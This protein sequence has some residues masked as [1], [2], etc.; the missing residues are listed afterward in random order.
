MPGPAT[1]LTLRA[2]D[3]LE[4]ERWLASSSLRTRLVQRA[5]IVLLAADGVSTQV[6]ADRVG[7]SRP[8]VNLWRS[9]YA[10][11]G[12]SGLA[13][14]DRSGR[15][16][17]AN[18]TTIVSGVADIA[19][20]P[21]LA[22]KLS[23]PR[24]RRA[25]V[26][27]QSLYARLDDGVSR[28]V[29]II[30]APAGFG[31]S[32]LLASWLAGGTTKGRSVAWLSLST[33]DNDPSLFWRY[34]I[35]A[36]SRLH[37]GVGATASALMGSPQPPRMATIL[38]TM[39]NDLHSVTGDV[40]IVLDDYQLIDSADIHQAMTFLIENR[41]PRLHLIILTRA[42]PPL[43]LSR[44]RASG[45]LLELRAADL[46]FGPDE[47]GTYLN[48]VMGL[49]LTATNISEL[50]RRTE[51]WVAGLQMAALA[52]RDQAEVPAFIAGFT[53]S[54]RYVIDYLAEEVLGRQPPAVRAFLLDTSVLD[55]MCASLCEEITSRHDSQDI[56]E[57]L[58]HAN[59][60]VDPL[61]EVRGW[62]RYHQLFADVLNQRLRHEQHGRVSELHR[63]ASAWYERHGLFTDAVQHAI[64]GNDVDRAIRLIE[65]GG[66]SLVLD[67]QVQT[68]LSWLD[69]L[70]AERVREHPALSTIRALGYVF[71]NRP[72]EAE[73]SLRDAERC[74]PGQPTTDGTRAVLG[75][76]AVIR[77]AICRF[78]GDI[79]RSVSLGQRA[80]QL[81]PET[82][83]TSRE[84]ASAR[85]HVALTYQVNGD[86]RPANERPLEEAVAAFSAAHALV[87]L[88]NSINRLGKF[89]TMQGRLRAAHATYERAAAAVSNR[90]GQ[91]AA[92]NSAAYYAGMGEIC[93]QWNDLDSAEKYL[94]QAVDLVAGDLTVD[95][96]AVTESHLSLARLHEARGRSVEAYA[97]L[98]QFLSLA[99]QR[100]FFH[101]LIQR[102]EAA[103]ARLALLQ[104]D[105][106]A[107]TGWADGYGDVPDTTYTREEQHLTLTRILIARA[108]N[109]SADYLNEALALLQRMFAA[110]TGTGRTNSV[111]EILVLQA[112]ALHARHEGS[113]AIQAVERALAL[114][115]SERYV[116]V[117]VDEGAPMA[118]LLKDLIQARRNTLH[119]QQLGG[120]LRYARRLLTEF[121]PRDPSG[122]PSS[123]PTPHSRERPVD[124]SLSGR[125]REVLGLIA[126][127]LSN[128]EIAA[129]MYVATSTVKSYTNSIFRRLGVSSRTQAVA[130][131]RSLGLLSD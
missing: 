118:A 35:A 70:P 57:G 12:L 69:E 94:R 27:R 113:A 60:F 23:V 17:R 126:A 53:G 98:D 81:L 82:D 95:A 36:I 80:L 64:R 63:R 85:T 93:L 129:R 28:A 38:T 103:L 33:A 20:D 124:D 43:P 92:V 9:R 75:R 37:P 26:P 47:S 62:Y 110:A 84:R 99:R 58:E 106:A 32:T 10:H 91:P 4:L 97:V 123:T 87:P 116:R 112:L 88:L 49:Q 6:I 34:F 56:L 39:I 104:H 119:D 55:R 96:D 5:Q 52:I 51:G 128:R 74:L 107:A 29:V 115:E 59:L 102:G 105:L 122:T 15:P 111:I 42:D 108:E 78:S 71:S 121:H 14:Q 19:S 48:Q 101:L 125:E 117:F 3:R 61:D 8:T 66:M 21:L 68:V 2:D 67:Q 25:V 22:T 114:A 65:S 76:V 30:S 86:V 18:E 100:A 7:V 79:E 45:E 50:V 1:A 41:P 16:S 130:E 31:K 89:R 54:N 11:S 127:G 46:R 77:A 40:I 73:A 83:A 131:A 24:A 13:D 120:P 109:G 44:L 90:E 72:D